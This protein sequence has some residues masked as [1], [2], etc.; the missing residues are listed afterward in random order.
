MNLYV[1]LLCNT[2]KI[3]NLF[4]DFIVRK[5][6]IVVFLCLFHEIIVVHSLIEVVKYTVLYLGKKLI[7]FI[8][9]MLNR[10]K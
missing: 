4:N 10:S 5:V 8:I 6:Y 1:W 3:Y 2:L 9:D 7:L